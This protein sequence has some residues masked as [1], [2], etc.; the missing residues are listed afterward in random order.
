[1]NGRKQQPLKKR[2]KNGLIYCAVWTMVRCLRLLPRR[3][4]TAV[5]AGTGRLGYLLA[6]DARSKTLHHLQLAYG[7]RKSSNEIQKMAQEVFVNLGRN[8]SD[9]VLL[10][11]LVRRGLDRYVRIVGAHHLDRAVE[12]GRGVII[13]TGHIGCWELLAATLVHSGYPLAVVGAELYDPRLNQLLVDTRS[14]AGYRAF[15]RD[16]GGVRQMLRWLRGGG[17]LGMLIDQDTR[18]D[19]EFVDFLGRPAHTPAG[20]VVLAQKTGAALVPLAIH[21]RPDGTHLAE[22]REEIPLRNGR[23]PRLGRIENVQRCSRAVE[24]FIREHPT[25][26]V[27]M[28]ERWKTEPQDRAVASFRDD[29]NRSVDVL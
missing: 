4:A 24:S 21:R 5:M 28:H 7:D 2:L 15:S 14:L 9:A 11:V 23:E 19:G 26:W 17:V 6:R 10:P 29:E 3:L 1:M 13:L 22:I 18:A 25:Q 27:W 12:R 8:A 16:S 20:P